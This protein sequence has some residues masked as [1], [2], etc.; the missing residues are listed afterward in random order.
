MNVVARE[1]AETTISDLSTT[2]GTLEYKYIALKNAVTIDLAHAKGFT[3]ASP[4]SFLAR[5]EG[6]QA[7]S[8]NGAR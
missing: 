1:K 7:L 8:Y 4:T 6:A 3:D 5:K 2:I